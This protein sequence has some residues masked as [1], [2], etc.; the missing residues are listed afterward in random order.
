[1]TPIHKIC[2]DMTKNY[3]ESALLELL[4]YCRENEWAGYDPYDALNSRVLEVL[5]FI[6][7]KLPRLVLTQALK[8]S[9]VNLR[10]VL[11]VQK[12]Q[13]AKGIALFLSALLKLPSL[14][15]AD[16]DALI[17]LMISRLVALRSPGV[18]Y[19][20]WGYSFPWQTRAEIVPSGAPNLVC[21][22]FVA[23]ALLDAYKQN[24]DSECLSMAV[25]AA[26]YI[27]NE[28]YWTDGRS[29][30]S[31]SYPL[32]SLKVQV[33]NANFLAAALLCRVYQC[34]GQ[35][36]LL[37]PA[38][39]AA[40]CSA[41]M[42]R[43]DG[44]WHYGEGPSQRWIDNFHTGYNLCA[45]HSISQSIRTG[46]FDLH[47][48]RGFAFYRA[49]FFRENGAVRY[50]HDRTYPVDIHCVA[51][52]IITL[53]AVRHLDSENIALAHKVLR[54]ALDH[55]WDNR[56]FFYYRIHR[57]STIRTSYMR[58]S[59][60]WMLLAMSTLLTEDP[61]GRKPSFSEDSVPS[62]KHT[63]S[64]RSESSRPAMRDGVLR[65]I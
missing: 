61:E 33:H 21:T 14:G 10:G 54:W 65:L 17:Q 29:I 39:R 34:T 16:R 32:A 46:E 22:T 63:S 35:E 3:V 1:M 38:L 62:S 37:V 19:W 51:Q 8:R 57:L 6:N 7:W 11:G 2:K 53:V 26:D 36:K 45:L 18:P 15:F 42:Q 59:Q 43:E 47:I 44:S 28:L 64:S 55:L 41:A 24:G 50:F 13:N 60:A 30:S 25:N 20:C 56:G 48:Q 12:K 58:W 23:N 52:S 40:H 31:F 49:H 27:V 4:A 5:P 9:P